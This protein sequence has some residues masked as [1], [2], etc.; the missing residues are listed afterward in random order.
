[1]NG[2]SSK[3]KNQWR[4]IF[5]HKGSI[6][7]NAYNSCD[8]WDAMWFLVASIWWN[9]YTL[10]ISSL[11]IMEKSVRATK[12]RWHLPTSALSYFLLIWPCRGEMYTNQ[13][14]F[15]KKFAACA[16]PKGCP[17]PRPLH[18]LTALNPTRRLT[19]HCTSVSCCHLAPA[20]TPTLHAAPQIH[21]QPVTQRASS[22]EK[23]STWAR[24]R[25]YYI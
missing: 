20:A 18:N 21:T 1:M 17:C 6:L 16:V 23:T 8:I 19:P 3:K 4:Q 2:Q 10:I 25:L 14:Q 15:A 7:P 22:W 11:L 5:Q 24:C 13:N 12:M 9:L